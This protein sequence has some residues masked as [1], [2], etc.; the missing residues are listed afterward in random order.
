MSNYKSKDP[1]EAFRRS[2][3]KHEELAWRFGSRNATLNAP[4]PDWWISEHYHQR[5]MEIQAK[6]GR[7][8]PLKY[9]QKVHRT[10]SDIFERKFWRPLGEPPRN[11]K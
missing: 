3:Q 11:K 8:L 6:E 4:H 7:I 9:R 2:Q 10:I 5:V 1:K